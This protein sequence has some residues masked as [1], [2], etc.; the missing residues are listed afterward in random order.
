MKKLTLT[1][2]HFSD[3][4][5]YI[6][7]ESV[8][9][10]DGHIEI[11]ANL[12]WCKFAAISATGFIL[13]LAGSGIKAGWGIEAGEGIEAGSGIEAGEG[14]LCK[15]KLSFAF[16]L[17]A[18]VAVWI[19]DPTPEQ[20]RVQCGEINDECAKRIMHG[21]LVIVPVEVE[22]TEATA[23]TDKTIPESEIN[24]NGYVY[25]LKISPKPENDHD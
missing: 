3:K 2:E 12:G 10:F 24:I 6:G 13:A 5:E 8:V 15:L 16:R 1:K 20:V 4:G 7:C 25:I 21:E 17:F 23:A 18:G 14:I 19:K 11:A 9:G 22:K